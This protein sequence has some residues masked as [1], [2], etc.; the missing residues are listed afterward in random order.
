MYQSFVYDAKPSAQLSFIFKMSGVASNRFGQFSP[1][2]KDQGNNVCRL[3]VNQ[4]SETPLKDGK[5]I[6]H[7]GNFFFGWS[8]NLGIL[9]LTEHNNED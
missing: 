2:K 6:M 7:L 3:V 1:L 5:E 9:S 4:E 8:I